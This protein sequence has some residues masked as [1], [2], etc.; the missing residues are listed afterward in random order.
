MYSNVDNTP[1]VSTI[2]TI[3]EAWPNGFPVGGD[4]LATGKY[5]AA[6]HIA[7]NAVNLWDL[8]ADQPH[9]PDMEWVSSN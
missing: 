1:K 3:L 2:P 5:L 8:M 6:R 4:E 7:G 9:S